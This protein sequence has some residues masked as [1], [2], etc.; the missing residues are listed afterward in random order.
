MLVHGVNVKV[1]FVFNTSARSGWGALLSSD[2]HV[3]YNGSFQS[4]G[5][6]LTVLVAVHNMLPLESMQ[7]A[8]NLRAPSLSWVNNL[9]A[10][11]SALIKTQVLQESSID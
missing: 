4:G 11:G 9:R 2:S 7:L 6:I 3:F 10:T 8:I 5:W 1:L